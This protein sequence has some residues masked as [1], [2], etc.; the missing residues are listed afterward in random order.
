MCGA[1]LRSVDSDKMFRVQGSVFRVQG[2]VFRVQ[3]MVAG[4][5]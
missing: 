4:Y 5:E 3:R 2:A 1:A